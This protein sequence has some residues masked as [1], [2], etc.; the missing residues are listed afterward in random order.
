MGRNLRT[1]YGETLVELGKEDPRIVVFDADLAEST[2]TCMFRKAFPDRF[3]DMGI[4]EGNMV[5]VAAGMAHSGFLPFVSTF[6]MFG[7]ARAFEEIRNTVAYTNLNV[8]FVFSHSG[9][10]VGEDGGS[11]QA[12]E[13]INL[14][15]G[16]P[17]MTILVPCDPEETRKAVL[18]AA[19]LDGPVYLRVAR[20]VVEDIT[21]PEDPFIPGRAN[22]LKEGEE[23]C[24]ISMGLMI[25]RA[26]KAAEQ[27][28]EMGI[29]TAVMNMHT[30]KPIDAQAL[31]D[32][33]RRY[34]AIVTLEEHS[35]IGGLGS[36]VAEVIAGHAGA[37]FERIGIQDKFG[38]SGK[39]EELFKAYGLTAEHVKEAVLRLLGRS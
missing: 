28:E 8:K 27:L 39:P 26:L 17:N 37:A 19:K 6:A 7:T 2:Q 16:L 35:V 24:I 30:I 33:S 18:A 21:R 12:I 36:A 5:D 9:L 38:R 31:L 13:D 15:R 20:P 23:A 3:F 25:P 34:K 10:S 1:V 32:A 4:A 22:M 29:S 14:M 11:H